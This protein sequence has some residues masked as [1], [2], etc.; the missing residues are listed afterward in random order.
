M[1]RAVH[2]EHLEEGIIEIRMD[3]REAQNRLSEPLCRELMTALAELKSDPALRVLLL[4]GQRD[5]FCGGATLDALQ[6]VQ[7]GAVDVLDLKLPEQ[8][9]AFP[10][11][12]VAAL[13]GHAVGGGMVLALCCDVLVAAETSR[14][15]FN[16][17]SMGFT[18]GM[19]TTALLPALIGHH[20]AM[21]MMLTARYYRGA[22]LRG[23]GLFNR[24]VS[25]DEVRGTALD[26]AQQMADKPRHVL[27]MVK[28]T[29]ALSRRRALQ[30]GM[31]SEHLMHQI[32]FQHADTARLIAENY[33]RPAPVPSKE[34]PRGES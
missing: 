34:E 29:L 1:S 19:G 5:V 28:G 14:Y 30:E 32:C 3:D 25:V 20:Q 13:E 11:P 21:E 22:E 27:E 2:V 4:S 24:V 15:S 23:R 16:F 10:V 12:I 33:I 31:W 18:P 26:L 6:S 7:T 17:T 8:M 9:L